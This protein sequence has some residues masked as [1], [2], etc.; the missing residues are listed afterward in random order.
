MCNGLLEIPRRATSPRGS[1]F[2]FHMLPRRFFRS[3]FG[4]SLYSDRRSL[5]FWRAPARRKTANWRSIQ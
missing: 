2:M 1:L 3:R 5:G 4:S